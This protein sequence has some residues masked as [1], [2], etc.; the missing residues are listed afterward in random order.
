MN[1]NVELL[2]AFVL[3]K[4]RIHP[5]EFDKRLKRVVCSTGRRLRGF[6]FAIFLIILKQFL[7]VIRVFKATENLG[8]ENKLLE[9]MYILAYHLTIMF[10]LVTYFR[11]R[12]LA[13]F[14]SVF[15][16]FRNLYPG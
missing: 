6:Q 14:L 12:E 1:L 7:Q 4:I 3:Q 5:F 2:T 13:S 15:A 9:I 8:V 10:L 11:Q 16:C